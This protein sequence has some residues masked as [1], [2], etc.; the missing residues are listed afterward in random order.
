[1][2][3]PMRL[4]LVV[5]AFDLGGGVPA[6]ALFVRRSALSLGRN[7]VHLLSLASARTDSVSSH[8]ARPSTWLRGPSFKQ[9]VWH[10]VPFTHVGTHFS[11]F[12][13]QRY[14]SR[15]ALTRLLHDCDV[16]QVVCGTPAWAN[17][18][19]GLGKPVSL[20]VATRARVE[21][22]QRDALGQG[23]LGAWRRAMTCI[24][25]RLDNRALQNVDAIQVENPWMLDYARKLN[26]GREVD[27]RYAPPGVDTKVFSPPLLQG[28]VSEP[29][30]LCVGRLADPR[31]NVTLLVEAYAR[32][33]TELRARHRL[34]LAGADTL[35]LTVLERAAALGVGDRI[36]QVV[37]PDQAALIELYRGA[38]AFAL[39]SDEEGF[40]VVVIE[41]MACGVPVVATRCG[42]P[43]G[44][45]SDGEDGFLVPRDDPAAMADRLTRL[46]LDP[47]LNQQMRGAAR[48]TVE[49]RFDEQAT[50]EVFVDVWNQLIARTERS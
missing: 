33:P 37:W 43:D 8:L 13:F 48:A 40:G 34:V 29:Y 35:P 2:N 39:P 49:R 22:L 7:D 28:L 3:R 21:R 19:I 1:M 26:V 16:I 20:Q 44:I 4:G 50:G 23:A 45:I 30:V 9:D 24:T 15:A 17:A 14:R 12:E 47:Q 11:E 27:I 5:P 25:D 6:V 42:G 38:S 41:A 32:L 18:V 36:T 10:G 31:K 46:L